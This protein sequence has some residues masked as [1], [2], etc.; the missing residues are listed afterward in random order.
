MFHATISPSPETG[1]RPVGEIALRSFWETHNEALGHAATLIAGPPALM[2]RTGI[3][4]P[5]QVPA[6]TLPFSYSTSYPNCPGP[7]R[8]GDHGARH[9]IPSVWRLASTR[10][11]EK[12][13]KNR[14]AVLRATATD[15]LLWQGFGPP[16]HR[17]GKNR[18]NPA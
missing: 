9:S 6:V 17:F 3:S 18:R 2:H 16:G 1:T 8:I 13:D 4:A 5:A 14:D 11:S 10:H 12:S 7:R 15:L